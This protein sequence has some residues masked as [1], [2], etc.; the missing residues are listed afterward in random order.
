MY[1]YVAFKHCKTTDLFICCITFRFDGLQIAAIGEK[2]KLNLGVKCA[3]VSII[4]PMSSETSS[5]QIIS[6]D[7]MIIFFGFFFQNQSAARNVIAD[8]KNL[9]F[10]IKKRSWTN[11]DAD[12]MLDLT[13]PIDKSNVRP[14]VRGLFSM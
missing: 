1:N 4:S 10:K 11:K 3:V 5:V 7:D 2:S 13:I 6:I 9:K 14:F 8:F 12:S